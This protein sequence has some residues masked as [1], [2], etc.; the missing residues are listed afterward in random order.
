MKS[1]E[2]V[3]IDAANVIGLA[4]IVITSYTI[5]NNIIGT[6][7]VTFG[8]I[9][10]IVVFLFLINLVFSVLIALIKQVIYTLRF[11]RN[12]PVHI[13][14]IES[15]LFRLE[16]EKS[17]KTNQPRGE[18]YEWVSPTQRFNEDIQE[19]LQESIYRSM[20]YIKRKKK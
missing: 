6:I 15:R 14:N 13:N 7:I 19:Q 4:A 10:G 17:S 20:G 2:V 16:Q 9:I 1:N 5:T 12:L 11:F 18:E 3:Q 8:L